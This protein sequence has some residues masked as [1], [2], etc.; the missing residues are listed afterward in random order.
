MVDSAEARS[1]DCPTLLHLSARYGL[2]EL[3]AR[4]VDLPD[5]RLACHVRDRHGCRPEDVAQQRQHRSLALFFHNFREMVR[6]VSACSS[7]VTRGDPGEGAERGSCPV[8][9]RKGAKPPQQNYFM[10]NDHKSEFSPLY[11]M[12]HYI[13]LHNRKWRIVCRF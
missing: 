12:L 13:T 11:S 6:P 9:R 3:A 5:A 7:G 4:L 8:A 2:E 10:T 1:Y